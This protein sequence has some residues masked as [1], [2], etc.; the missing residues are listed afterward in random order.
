MP[1][2]FFTIVIPTFNSARTLQNALDSIFNQHFA[3]LE[4]L[5]IDGMSKDATMDIIQEN[6]IRNPVI[7]FVSEKDAGVYD[8]F[9]KSLKMAKGEWIYFLGS[10]DRMHGAVV[11]QTVYHTLQENH[12]DMLYGNVL[13]A[14][15]KQPYDGPF[16]MEKL[17]NRNISHQ[18]IFYN[19]RVFKKLGGYNLRYKIMADWEFNLKCFFRAGFKEIYQDLI[20]TDFAAGGLSKESDILFLR[21]IIIPE[22]LSLMNAENPEWYLKNIS[23]YDGWWRLLRNTKIRTSAEL[24][25]FSQ[26]QSIPGALMNM[27]SHQR[28]IS[29]DF[30]NNGYISKIC[31]FLSFLINKTNRFK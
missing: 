22:K 4:I 15:Y 20:I 23:R 1:S 6:C 26:G 8:A 25:S 24:I 28:K 13:F 31:M 11:L 30:L 14:N 12:C 17:L 19:N 9:N 10:D 29:A 21:E 5:I 16:T 2:P 18:A 7:R 3:D 27:Q